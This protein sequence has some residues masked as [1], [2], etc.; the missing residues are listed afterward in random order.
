[1]CVLCVSA[2]GLTAEVGRLVAVVQTVVVAVALPALLDAAIVLAGELARLA[3]G[4]RHVGR[5]GWG[6]DQGQSGEQTGHC[7]KSRG[8]K[9]KD[10]LLKRL[11]TDPASL[12]FANV[13]FFFVLFLLGVGGGAP[14]QIWQRCKKMYKTAATP[15]GKHIFHQTLFGA[16]AKYLSR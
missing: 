7:D 1:M 9:T 13:F 4:R 12:K 10:S 6:R 5:V 2:D 15:A 16:S 11:A 14:L 3:L 8:A